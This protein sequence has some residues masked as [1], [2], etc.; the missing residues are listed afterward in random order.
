MFPGD[1]RLH[2][3]LQEHLLRPAAVAS[4]VAA[5]PVE[6]ALQAILHLYRLRRSE[7][8]SKTT[9]TFYVRWIPQATLPA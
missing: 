8:H 3:K 9:C 2:R 5:G 7:W 4:I 1:I 6:R